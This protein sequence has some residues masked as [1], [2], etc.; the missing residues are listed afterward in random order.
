MADGIIGEPAV[1][2]AA[3]LG[4]DRFAGGFPGGDV[5]LGH[6]GEGGGPAGVAPV[7][8][9][10]RAFADDVRRALGRRHQPRHRQPRFR[11]GLHRVVAR[12]RRRALDEDRPA[13]ARSSR[14]VNRHARHMVPRLR[15]YGSGLFQRQV[16][17]GQGVKL[18]RL[19]GR[20]TGRG[21]RSPFHSPGWRSPRTSDRA[22]TWRL[23]A[24]R[25]SP[26]RPPRGRRPSAVL[27]R[28]G[29]RL[30]REAT[31]PRPPDPV[32]W[33]SFVMA[34]EGRDRNAGDGPDVVEVDL[35]GQHVERGR[36]SAD[37]RSAT[38][39]HH[40]SFVLAGRADAAARRWPRDRAPGPRR[41]DRPV[42]GRRPPGR[43]ARRPRQQHALVAFQTPP[44]LM[45]SATMS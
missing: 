28:P 10:D 11:R 29:L 35:A 14:V 33:K 27:P 37:R 24:D 12:T 26:N 21:C 1:V 44:R 16:T 7:D 3:I 15:M 40:L 20:E 25:W 36:C 34:I 6:G 18:G 39:H 45:C 5:V 13:P 41:I 2:E 8:R 42:S 19:D 30:P 43:R 4:E 22:P 23:K 17:G 9:A 38:G 31:R 32:V